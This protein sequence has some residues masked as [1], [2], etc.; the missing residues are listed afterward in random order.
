M[1]DS[2]E[3]GLFLDCLNP[4]Y[5]H[6]HTPYIRYYLVIVFIALIS[7]SDAHGVFVFLLVVYV[8]GLIADVLLIDWR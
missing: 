7:L 4:S 1:Y 6:F 5:S 2:C 8:E 3:R